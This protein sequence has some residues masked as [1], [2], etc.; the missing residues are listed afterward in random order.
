MDIDKNKKE[1]QNKKI[2]NSIFKNV[3][4]YVA[5]FRFSTNILKS[6]DF[7]NKPK[8]QRIQ[9]RS[10]IVKFS[11]LYNSSRTK[12]YSLIFLLG[13]FVAIITL[14]LFKNTG[15]YTAGVTGVFQGLAGL[16][17]SHMNNNSTDENTTRLVSNFVYWGLYF[18]T[19]IPLC[20]FAYKKIS[21]K[22]AILTILYIAVNQC[23]GFILDLIPGVNNIKIFGD[24]ST[25]T[26][27]EYIKFL[28]W[29]NA[30]SKTFSLFVYSIVAGFCI[31]IPY[32]IIY[33]VGASTGGSDVVSF[34]YAKIKN[35]NIGKSLIVINVCCTI[36]SSLLGSFG[37]AFISSQKAVVLDGNPTH[38]VEAILS[39]NLVFSAIS[40]TVLGMIINIFFPKTR[41]VMIKIH[42]KKIE[43]IREHLILSHYSKGFSFYNIIGGYS[44]KE[45][46]VLETTCMFIDLPR[47]IDIIRKVDKNAL[48]TAIK[49]SDIDGTMC[50]SSK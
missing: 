1:I 37:A 46:K 45:H 30:G 3:W 31:G 18:L 33:I 41:F 21:K 26:I 43:E 8:Y 28:H 38:Y 10:E 5:K 14:F 11:K 24:T 36:T 40:A 22:L 29:D 48:V 27:P 42:S 7:S 12:T 47:I 49:I 4:L 25:G 15:I 19:N 50:V 20:I 16:I 13:I 34:Y 9:L 23:F 44:L 39:P 17:K 32:S 35:K 6:I 2:K